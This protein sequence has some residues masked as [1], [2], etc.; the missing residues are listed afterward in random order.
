M[1]K[2]EMLLNELVEQGKKDQ[3]NRPGEQREI[4]IRYAVGREENAKVYEGTPGKEGVMADSYALMRAAGRLIGDYT[5]IDGDKI[6][7]A[8]VKG[9]MDQ[10]AS[11]AIKK[12]LNS[13]NGLGGDKNG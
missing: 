1:D 13:L 12:V 3:G 4:V 10:M 6:A 2:F 9:A 8:M 7:D 11:A 5:H